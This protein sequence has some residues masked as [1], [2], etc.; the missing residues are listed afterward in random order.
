MADDLW[1]KSRS[2]KSE[3][4]GDVDHSIIGLLSECFLRKCRPYS[5]ASLLVKADSSADSDL[6]MTKPEIVAQ[7]RSPRC[8]ISVDT[9][10]F[11]QMVHL[12]YLHELS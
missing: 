5:D 11:S 12:P 2:V 1:K 7:V 6:Y 8:T 9:D 10:F 4:G 3:G